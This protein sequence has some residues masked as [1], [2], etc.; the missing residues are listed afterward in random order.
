MISMSL[1]VGHKMDANTQC[2]YIF[3][4]IVADGI[5]YLCMADESFGRRIPYAF[6][7][8]IK[9]RFVPYERREGKE[10]EE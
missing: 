8:N 7:D 5:T 3:H 1:F 10:V 6:L 4:Y 9:N 2:R